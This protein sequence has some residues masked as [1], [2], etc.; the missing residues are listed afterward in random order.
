MVK[1]NLKIGTKISVVMISFVVLSVLT[2]LVGR[3]IINKFQLAA[4]THIPTLDFYERFFSGS[5]MELLKYVNSNM[6]ND[7]IGYDRSDFDFQNLLIFH[8]V[9]NMKERFGPNQEVNFDYKI[10][11]KN[12]IDY[13]SKANKTC[14]L[15]AELT[16]VRHS[17]LNTFH[18]IELLCNNSKFTRVSSEIHKMGD[19]EYTILISKNNALFTTISENLTKLKSS[20]SPNESSEFLSLLDLYEKGF[21]R[22]KELSEQIPNQLGQTENSWSAS[23]WGYASGMKAAI[24]M[25]MGDMQKNINTY[26]IVIVLV[27]IVIGS[28]FTFSIVRSINNGVKENYA[29]IE[30]IANG[31]LSIK[32]SENSL[33]RGDEFGQLSQKLHKMIETLKSVITKISVS[34]NDV[35]IAG[36]DLKESS[37]D[38]ASGANVQASSLEE[39]SASMEEMVSNIEQNTENAHQAKELAESLSSKIITVNEASS[40]SISSIKDITDRIT[41]INEIAFQTNLLALNAAVEAARAG[42]FGRGFSVVATE[43]KKLAERCRAAADEIHVISQNSVKITTEASALLSDIIPYIKNTTAIVQTIASASLEQR[44]GSEQINNAIQQLNQLTQQY[45]ATSDNLSKKSQT[46]DQMASDLKEQITIFQL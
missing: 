37:D 7:T 12:M 11:E 25:A 3:V 26:Y 15:I 29:V 23:Y 40:K 31:D 8:W 36:T 13:V 46:L 32:I 30:S 45:A 21:I 42:E 44:S 24:V 19:M 20:L 33:Q 5:R 34:T 17:N 22:L 43:V 6:Y 4:S 39:I 38:I 18:K 1:L 27:I 14:D 28:I 35:S 2:A 9:K 16:V 10:V 41:I